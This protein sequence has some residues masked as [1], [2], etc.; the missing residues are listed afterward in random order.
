MGVV[1]E[2]AK[3]GVKASKSFVGWL[4]GGKGAVGAVRGAG[5]LWVGWNVMKGLNDGE[6]LVGGLANSLGKDI[7]ETYNENGVIGAGEVLLFGE[8]SDEK[9]LLGNMV[10]TVAGK[11]TYEKT[12][13]TMKETAHEVSD[14]MGSQVD[15]VQNAF[16]SVGQS[17]PQEPYQPVVS[18]LSTMSSPFS[19]VNQ[20]V[21]NMTGGK[22]STLNLASLLTAA[23]M[24]FG[25]RFGW[26]GT[27]AG[28]MLGT[29]TAKD[30]VQRQAQQQ[31]QPYVYNP[32]N[33]INV[34]QTNA[35]QESDNH[36]IS[37][38]RI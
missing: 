11:G 16:Q 33:N 19:S 31:M 4:S 7:K 1:K 20:M 14:F 3:T 27:I 29:H 17:V 8:K 15:R 21:E 30:M 18:P 38:I 5:G 35:E 37:R 9:S 13:D 23:Y 26:M 25:R 28:I 34:P 32:I 12:A 22:M 10:D 6:G 2:I 24:I 36:T